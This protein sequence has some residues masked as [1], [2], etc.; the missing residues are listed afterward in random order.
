MEERERR[1]LEKHREELVSD[2]ADV[3]PILDR[4]VCTGVFRANDDN[5]QLVRSEKTPLMQ[6][7]KL[8]D[9]L[10]SRG[11]D[12]FN[13][14]VEA[15]R[16]GR[17]ELAEVLG[18]SLAEMVAVS[19]PGSDA[20]VGSHRLPWPPGEFEPPTPSHS[21]AVKLQRALRKFHS[22][23]ARR[24]PLF[25]F[26]PSGD[27]VGL[28]EVFVTLSTLDFR[29]LQAMF[30]ETKRL[31]AE[32]IRELA[33]KTWSERRE[34]VQEITELKRLLRLSNGELA[35]GTLLLA[36][37][38]GGKTLTLMKI[39]SLWAEGR[40]E[41]VQQFEFV[42]YVSGRNEEALKGKSATDVLRLDEFDLN[43]SEQDEMEKYLSENSDKVLVLLDGADE[44]GDLWT[45]SKGLE[46]IFERKGALRNCSFIVS[47]RPC[48]AAYQLIPVCDQHFHLAGLS[49]QRLEELLVRRLGEADGRVV[50]NELTQAKWSQLRALMKETPMVAN[51][52]AAL[53]LDGQ[54]LPSTR[55]ELYTV[56]VV[57]MVRR[58]TAKSK[59]RSMPA[60]TLDD[61]PT[62]AKTE[63]VNI[64]QVALKGLKR[65]RYVF[66]LEKEVQP[67]CGDAAQRLGFVE[68]FRT[69]SVRGH[70][71]EVQF[72][73]L[74]FQEYIAAY[75]VAHS[76]NVECELESCRQ[77]IGFGEETVPFWHFVSG[78][79]GRQ[80]AEILMLFLSG[81]KNAG[82]GRSSGKHLL[83]QMSCF[84]EAVEQPYTD[85]IMG[86][87]R[88][89]TSIKE[90]MVAFFPEAVDFSC[91][92]LSL[93]EFHALG[94]SLSYSSHVTKLDLSTT[95][96]NTD[97]VMA[98]YAPG[99]VQNVHCLQAS[100]NPR[101][102]GEGMTALANA[103]GKN[104]QL[105]LLRV[106]E[107]GLD[108]DDCAALKKI[109]ITNK[110]LN[111]IDLFGNTLSADALRFLLPTLASSQLRRL[112]LGRTSMDVEGACAMGEVVVANPTLEQLFLND[113]PLGNRGTVMLLESVK[114]AKALEY[115]S[116]DHVDA[117]CGIVPFLLATM[118]E[119][120]FGSGTEH[121]QTDQPATPL[122]VSLHRNNISTVVLEH[123]ASQLP[124]R[125][126]RDQIICGMRIVQ[127]GEMRMQS[128]SGHFADYAQQGGTGEL[129]MS[130]MGIDHE[131]VAQ[132]T[133]HIEDDRSAVEALRLGFNSVH[134]YGAALLAQALSSNSTLRALVLTS[135]NI[136][137]R[138]LSALT[139]ALVQSNTSL[140]WL[141][142]ERNPI[143]GGNDCRSIAESQDLLGQLLARSAGLKYLGLSQ[144]GL[145]DDECGVVAAVLSENRGS[146]TF[147]DLDGNQ[148]SDRGSTE[149]AGGLEQNTTVRY[150]C[151]SKN[152][153]DRVGAAA[154]LQCARV[155]EQKGSR[156]QCVWMAGNK[157]DA[158]QLTGCMVDA[159]FVYTNSSLAMSTYL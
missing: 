42:F 48:E 39:A 41:F 96:L 81:S 83:F 142:L 37:A 104:G 94:V 66:N 122:T 111:G 117:D 123:L 27:P 79:L 68:E 47:S 69:M 36:Q 38:A 134:D 4:L 106:A 62:E 131:G 159:T 26:H 24:L 149:L 17:S 129:Y 1:V 118:Q 120:V 44:G 54:P 140:Q 105:L 52:V 61:L 78:M 128:L 55:T 30:A 32:K 43:G 155:R 150:L 88:S 59:K 146:I 153:I 91:Q 80:K 84:A 148:I 101:L 143:F 92:I 85:N 151:L 139:N 28:D 109:L 147:L 23:K 35:D 157:M 74:T 29:E 33:S 126:S 11:K 76:A 145:G 14:F 102:H 56:M 3:E 34:N 8:L 138:G 53:R 130:Y 9:I 110:N 50:A 87:E 51:M 40:E 57:N 113:N 133:G 70:W 93:S 116:M 115:L 2:I 99:G 64:G 127:H 152:Q 19:G 49:E 58:A 108:I 22:R 154:I 7:R 86:E 135:N 136:G 67:V 75:F 45:E 10:P 18:R 97:C 95:G 13:H 125:S 63:L 6:A 121:L 114:T 65:Q 21:T 137:C 132:I 98:L 124:R 82:K 71:H 144:T 77:A 72:C 15:L 107:C 89:A 46:K 156:I 103:L 12:A 100:F 5:V 25:D 112:C 158:R 31:S 20:G 119:R 16:S 60:S 141:E 90:A 73:H